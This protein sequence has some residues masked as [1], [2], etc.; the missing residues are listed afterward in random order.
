MKKEKLQP[1]HEFVSQ[2][3]LIWPGSRSAEDRNSWLGDCCKNAA[4]SQVL[5]GVI[6]TQ[7]PFE[8]TYNGKIVEPGSR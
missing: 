2:K 8:P 7:P 1:K 5:F 4:G 3:S 6:T